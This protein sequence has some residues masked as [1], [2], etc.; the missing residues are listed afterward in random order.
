M[1]QGF[2]QLVFM[3]LLVLLL[4]LLSGILDFG[5]IETCYSDCGN[6]VMES[7]RVRVFACVRYTASALCGVNSRIRDYQTLTV[8]ALFLPFS[9][10]HENPKQKQ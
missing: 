9:F 8:G 3:L 6:T 5:Q 2:L 1:D 4:L 7:V 10:G